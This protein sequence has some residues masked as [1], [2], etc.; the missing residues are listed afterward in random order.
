MK[1]AYVRFGLLLVL[2]F[3]LVACSGGDEGEKEVKKV[4]KANKD[5]TVAVNATLTGMDPHD[6]NDTLSNS[7]Q[8][9]MIEGLV[10]FDEE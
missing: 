9:T 1:K 4:D 10:G 3:S 6:T 8:K 5:V 2:I 7:V